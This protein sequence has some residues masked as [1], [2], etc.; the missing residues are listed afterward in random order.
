MRCFNENISI[1][2]K[3]SKGSM[4]LIFIKFYKKRIQL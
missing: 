3:N 2:V 1:S 4:S